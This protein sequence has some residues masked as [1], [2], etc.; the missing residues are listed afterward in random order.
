MYALP[1]DHR[2][3]FEHGLFGWAGA[4]PPGRQTGFQDGD[5]VVRDNAAGDAALSRCQAARLH[6]LSDYL[7]EGIH[8]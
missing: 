6:R 2:D 3:S 8:T 5:D 7:R 1:F 4:L